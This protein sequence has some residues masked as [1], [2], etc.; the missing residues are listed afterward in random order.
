MSIVQYAFG[1][2]LKQSIAGVMVVWSIY[3][4]SRVLSKH[5]ERVCTVTKEAAVSRKPGLIDARSL[6]INSWTA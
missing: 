6:E 4:V 3:L 1:I 5:V 2:K